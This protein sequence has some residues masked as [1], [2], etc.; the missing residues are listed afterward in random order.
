MLTD[1]VQLAC[2]RKLLCANVSA[3]QLF[4]Q[5]RNEN[6]V[7]DTRESRGPTT[8]H[9]VHTTIETIESQ[10]HAR[11]NATQVVQTL[12]DSPKIVSI[13]FSNL[14]SQCLIFILFIDLNR[15]NDQIGTPTNPFPNRA[16]FCN[17]IHNPRKRLHESEI[18][19]VLVSFWFADFPFW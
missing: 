6:E 8:K 18:K 5:R 9:L 4:D 16:P 13:I 10:R 3:E 12:F 7:C 19:L 2:E 17:L 15:L 11:K 1:S 14:V